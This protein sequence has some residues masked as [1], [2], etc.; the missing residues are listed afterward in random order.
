MAN[1][2]QFLFGLIWPAHISGNL[3][4]AYVSANPQASSE[5][6]VPSF[7]VAQRLGGRFK[8]LILAQLIMVPIGAL[9]TPLMFGLLEKTYGIGLGDGQLSAPTGLKIASLAMV[10]E[11]G[12]A[13]LPHGALTASIIAIFVGV[14]FEV[15]LSMRRRDAKGEL[16]LDDDGNTIQK[17]PWIPIP[18]AFGFGLILPPSMT[19]GTAFGSVIA[20]VWKKFAPNNQQMFSAP[21]ASGLIAGEAIIASILL[22]I[23]AVMMELLKPYL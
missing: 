14:I 4:A 15:L 5:N 2:T 18:S 20:T 13:A 22:P 11:K 3:A 10:M 12:L 8:T 9:L 1:A 17:F 16:M 7:W 19:L 21:L 6:V 23:L